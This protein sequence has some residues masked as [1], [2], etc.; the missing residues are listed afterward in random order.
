MT[1]EA[2][3]EAAFRDAVVSYGG[4]D[5]VVA[6]AGIASAA[7]FEDTSLELWNRNIAI[8][9]TGYFLSARAGYRIMKDQGLG[10]SI[11]FIASKNALAASPGASAYCAA[12]AAEVHLARCLA[13]EGAPQASAPIPSIR[14]PCCADRKS[15]RANGARSARPRTRWTNRELEEVYRQRSLLKLSVYPEDIA[16]A[17]YFFASDLSAKSTGNILNVD[18]GNAVSFTR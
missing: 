18:A 9:A 10:G 7:A 6:N 12:K 2:A 13:L 5:I 17:V 16:E 15:G 11:I 1:D 14:T 3:T 8:L 4:I